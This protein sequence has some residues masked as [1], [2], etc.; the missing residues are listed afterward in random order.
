M[1]NQNESLDKNI[2]KTFFN[3]YEVVDVDDLPDA[4]IQDTYAHLRD[5]N[6]FDP[7]EIDDEDLEF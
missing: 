4:E 1:N 6:W 2:E 5:E 7:A 3:G